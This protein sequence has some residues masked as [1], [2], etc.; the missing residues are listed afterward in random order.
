MITPFPGMGWGSQGAAEGSV[1]GANVPMAALCPPFCGIGHYP[2]TQGR[3]PVGIDPVSLTHL[4]LGLSSCSNALFPIRQRELVLAHFRLQLLLHQNPAQYLQGTEKPHLLA[5][6][7]TQSSTA[8][9]GKPLLGMP[10]FMMSL[11][12]GEWLP[13]APLEEGN[14]C[15]FGIFLNF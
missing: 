6:A 2:T 3:L 5:L 10:L 7:T 11:V 12:R 9:L 14:G 15:G 8:H 13:M 1:I 4:T